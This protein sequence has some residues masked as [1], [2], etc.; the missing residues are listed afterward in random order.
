MGRKYYEPGLKGFVNKEYEDAK[1][2]LYACFVQRDCDFAK[3]NGFVGMVTIP[4]EI[5]I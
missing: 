2:D 4:N 5:F 1:A 3:S